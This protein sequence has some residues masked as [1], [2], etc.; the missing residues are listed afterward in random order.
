MNIGVNLYL[1]LYVNRCIRLNGYQRERVLLYLKLIDIPEK[2]GKGAGSR[3]EK[4][5]FGVT[6]KNDRHHAK[7][8]AGRRTN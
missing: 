4:G 3:I 5:V 7:V 6:R 1:T 8:E 2:N